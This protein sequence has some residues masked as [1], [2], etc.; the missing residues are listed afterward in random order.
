VLVAVVA[1]VRPFDFLLAVGIVRGI[2][3]FGVGLLALWYGVQAAVFV[4]NNART[5]SLGFAAFVLVAGVAWIW[6]RK[7]REAAG[8]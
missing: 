8:N 7:R 1:G 6:Y 2:R 4:K 3:Y 5:V